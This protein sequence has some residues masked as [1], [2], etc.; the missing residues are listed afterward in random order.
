MGH[1]V[2]V[3]ADQDTIRVVEE[4]GTTTIL[5]GQEVVVAMMGRLR[6][7]ALRLFI[8]IRLINFVVLTINA[9]DVRARHVV[10]HAAA[11]MTG[12]VEVGVVIAAQTVAML[13][14]EVQYR[15]MHSS[16]LYVNVLITLSECCIVFFVQRSESRSIS[17]DR[18][19]DEFSSGES[20]PER[21]S[22][23]VKSSKSKDKKKKKSDKSS[24][25]KSR[26]PH[27]ASKDGDNEEN[28]E[29]GIPYEN[30]DNNMEEGDQMGD[31]YESPERVNGGDKQVIRSAVHKTPAAAGSKSDGKEAGV[32]AKSS[33]IATQGLSSEQQAM[34]VSSNNPVAGGSKHDPSGPSPVKDQRK[35]DSQFLPLEEEL[36]SV[37]RVIKR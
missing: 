32:S 20:S 29:D 9:V 2:G 25:K 30:D 36:R 13:A 23:K 22:P 35:P 14:V 4:V 8:R 17:R 28:E 21:K 1:L 5:G 19:R 7:V 10:A 16:C 11:M 15:F 18:S 34:D 26:E 33:Q 27:S 3:V 31:P 24:R 6:S 37:K 12:T